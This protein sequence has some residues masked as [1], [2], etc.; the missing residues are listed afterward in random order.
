MA[1]KR[2]PMMQER[3]KKNRQQIIQTARSIIA[4]GGFKDAQVSTI[5]EQAGISTGLIY[6]YF[7]SKSQLMVEILTDAVLHE[8]HLINEI[9]KR[10][11]YSAQENLISAIHSFVRR[12]LAGSKLAY[13]FMTEP[14]D[15]LVEAERI[16]CRKLFAQA[17][18]QIL[19][20]GVN[21]N[22][23]ELE[24]IDITA[25]CIIGAMTEAVVSPIT[26]NFESPV[27]KEKII[28]TIVDFCLR[29]VSKS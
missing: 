8:V 18:A 11:E 29:G 12:A 13:A 19:S 4:V 1:Y 3:L 14:V 17:I 5:A 21:S 25:N 26:P 6:R 10:S 20:N 23:F 24:D 9:G 27:D 28:T 22:E 16:R 2:S 7:Q 15:T